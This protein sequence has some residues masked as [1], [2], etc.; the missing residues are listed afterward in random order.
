MPKLWTDTVDEHRQAVREATIAATATL[1]S[2]N[3]LSAVT[4]SRI[5][6]EA[7]IGRATLYRY[8]SDVDEILLAWHE[9]QV[10]SH[11]EQL[12]AV[13]AR[14]DDPKDQLRAVLETYAL[15]AQQRPT[16]GLAAVLHDG[17]HM[18]RAQHELLDFIRDMLDRAAR[19]GSVRTDVSAGE[20]ASYCL[21]A[22][23]G[24]EQLRSKAAARRLVDVVIS[25]L[26]PAR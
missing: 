6:E 23:S 1:V 22:L 11:L 17:S 10:T 2:A 7:G 14:F 5:A 18:G 21:H 13:G 15:L 19:S 9:G 26:A 12:R 8:F 24:A 20:L 25:G 4:M 16:G 3:G